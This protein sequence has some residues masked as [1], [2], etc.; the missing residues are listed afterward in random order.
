MERQ[1]YTRLENTIE[2]SP[3]TQRQHASMDAIIFNL[4]AFPLGLLYFIFIVTGLSLGIGTIIIW[5]GLPITF[6]TLWMIRGMGSIER[7]LIR[8]LLHIPL[9]EPTRS[10]RTDTAKRG[11]IQRSGEMLRDPLTWTHLIYM[12]LKF[13]LSIISFVITV[14]FASVS[15]ALLLTPLAYLIMVFL[16]QQGIIPA[17]VQIQ[18]IPVAG[19]SFI[20]SHNYFEPVMLM[21]SFMVVPAGLLLGLLT[22]W[23][24]A[25]MAYVSG[26]LARALL[27]FDKQ[28]A[29]SFNYPKD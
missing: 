11:L 18:I 9:P 10:Y 8:S 22:R 14:T 17:D 1:F 23:L 6:V 7:Q 19:Q 21:R 28:A 3:Y 15:A 29:T 26:A 4:L 24:L 25:K 16:T 5:I 12:L 2:P 20:T 13:P 27:C